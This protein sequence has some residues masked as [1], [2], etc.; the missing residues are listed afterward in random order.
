MSFEFAT[1]TRVIFGR[2]V[3]AQA[4]EVVVGLG[5]RR[6]LLVTGKSPQRAEPLRQQL[7]AA[8]IDAIELAVPGEPTVD[9]ARAGVARALAEG[10]QAVVAFGGGSALDAGKAIAGLAANGGDP[11]DY[12]EV[13]GRGRALERP[14]LPFLAIP[15][16]AGTG[17]EVT[18]NAVLL[19]P[20]QR[21]KVSLRSPHLLPRAAI[22]DPE[23]LA[24]APPSVLVASGLDALAQLIEPF[25]SGRANP[26][27]D[28][29]A[30]E[31]IARSVRS[32]RRAVLEGADS[33]RREDLA[34]ASLL[35][36]LCLANAGLGAVHGFAAPAGGMFA[37]P[38]GAV[39][40]A[41]LAPAMAVNL[42]ALATRAPAHPA[43]ARFEELGGLLTGRA[44]AGGDDAVA[45]LAALSQDLGVVGLGRFGM[46]AGDV[47]TL[48]AKAKV[49]S[50]MKGNPLPLTDDE[51]TEIAQRAL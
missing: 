30:R 50:S 27:T 37:A 24:G 26:V 48:V 46:T 51:L 2:G 20:D 38:H 41:L 36:G 18:R 3:L 23:L 14:S 47:P 49:A 42:R 29:L 16:T 22:I 32:L 28:G 13:I 45:W 21:V 17:S 8:G 5:A 44:Q 40:A 35:G 1:A 34:I 6:L 9:L 39:C 11:L 43:R 25:I 10:C 15:T 4:A 12:L 19:A 31:G 7:R 33:D